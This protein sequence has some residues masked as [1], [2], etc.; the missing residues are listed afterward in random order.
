MG[1]ADAG[2]VWLELRADGEARYGFA[3]YTWQ[4]VGDTLVLTRP[5][6]RLTL[7][8]APVADGFLL[9]GP[10][11]GR[12][13]LQAAPLPPQTPAARP[14]RPEAWCGQWIHRATGGHLVLAL[15]ADGTYRMVQVATGGDTQS[16]SGQWRA[17]RGLV[18]TPDGGAEQRYAARWTEKGLWLSGGDLPLE[19]HFR[20]QEVP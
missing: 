19:V 9:E 11:F 20:R 14:K 17:D 8:V 13:H 16:T 4:H 6:A 3:A 1:T 2:Q 5:D 12:V 10:P 7:K 18:L 15:E